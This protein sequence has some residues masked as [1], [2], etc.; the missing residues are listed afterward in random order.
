MKQLPTIHILNGD[1]SLPALQAAAFPGQLLVWREILSEGPALATL[2][3][4]EFWEQRQ[5]F[6]TSSYKETKENYRR[7]VLD[8]LPK[9]Q[10]TGAFFEVILWFDRDLMCQVNLLYL[11]HRLHEIK[12]DIVSLCMPRDGKSISELTHEQVQQ[13]YRDRVQ[14]SKAQ[15]KQASELWQLYGGPDPLNLQLY[16]AQREIFIPSVHKALK[17]LFHRF[18]YCQTGLSQPESIIL[19]LISDG[20]DSTDVLIEQFQKQNPEYGFGDLQILHILHRLQPDLVQGREALH[21]SFFGE[22]VMQ[23]LASFTPKARW[24]GGT[25]IEPSSYHCFNSETGELTAASGNSK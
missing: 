5:E 19:E 10:E 25:K 22:R 20:A 16:L 2:P 23:G 14:Q 6:I 8:E 1:A 15:L 13:L 17:L 11:L 12:P 4:E 9:L 3:E 7:K 21:L 24:L 18:P